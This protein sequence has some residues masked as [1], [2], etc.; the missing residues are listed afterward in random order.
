ME[1]CNVVSKFVAHEPHRIFQWL[2]IALLRQYPV[3]HIG[4]LAKQTR[5]EG[6]VSRKFMGECTLSCP[7]SAASGLGHSDRWPVQ[8]QQRPHPSHRELGPSLVLLTCPN[9]VGS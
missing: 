4:F 5:R 6:H 3:S 9:L 2:R 1:I 8:P 7:E